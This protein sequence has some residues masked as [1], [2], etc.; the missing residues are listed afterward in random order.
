MNNH[1]EIEA[2]EK[3]TGQLQ[4][5]HKEISLLAKKAPSDGVNNF[6][7][8]LINKTIAVAN[9]VLGAKY[10]PLDDFEGFDADDAPSTSD[11]TLVLAQYL[12]EA[13]RYRADNIKSTHAGWFYVL[14]GNVS[15]VRT[16]APLKVGR[17]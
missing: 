12:E 16:G 8:G 4:G 10:A 3:I 9:D 11:V 14:D 2:L 13:E 5:F 1:N 17:K 6:K 15:T 7:L